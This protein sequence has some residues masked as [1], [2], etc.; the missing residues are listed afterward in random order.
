MWK[1]R[2]DHEK[3]AHIAGPSCACTA[4]EMEKLLLLIRHRL[5][6]ALQVD[7]PAPPNLVHLDAVLWLSFS[8]QGHR[9]PNL[10][11]L[12][13]TV[14]MHVEPPRATT[15]CQS[16]RR[17]ASPSRAPAK[18]D[19]EVFDVANMCPPPGDELAPGSAAADHAHHTTP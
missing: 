3:E 13:G 16:A 19:G 7:P 2:R 5:Q 9:D 18:D 15:H 14:S 17:T 8:V 10:A 12:M 11:Q 4:L 6:N 1:H